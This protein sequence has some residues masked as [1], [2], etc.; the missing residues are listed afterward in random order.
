VKSLAENMGPECADFVEM[1]LADYHAQ[2]TA[3]GEPEEEG[4]ACQ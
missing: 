1:A 3:G 4:D 2:H